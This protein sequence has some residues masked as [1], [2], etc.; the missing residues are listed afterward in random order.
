MPTINKNNYI[1]IAKAIGI[2]L[3]VVGHSGCPS[4]I[5]R[6]LYTFHMPLFFFCSGYL[7]KE[8]TDTETYKKYAKRKIK[9]LY[10][11]Y[12]KWSVLFLLLHN[13][14][15]RVNIYNSITH[16]SYYDYED[17]IRQLL[18]TIVMSDYELL[19]RPFWFIKALLLASIGVASISVLQKYYFKNINKI[20]LLFLFHILTGISKFLPS[21]PIIGDISIPLFGIVYF[22]TGLLLNENKHYLNASLSILIGTFIIV[23]IGCHLYGSVIDM[24]YTTVTNYIPYY[25]LSICGVIMTFIVSKLLERT[26]I[27]TWFYYIGNHTMPILALNLLALKIGNLI[28]IWYYDLPIE[29]LSSYTII[30]DYNKFF[31]VLYT[32]I[33]IC[34]PLIIHSIHKRYYTKFNN[35]LGIIK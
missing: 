30:G 12:L 35:Y 19:L 21:I 22:Y 29:I 20:Q 32:I 33:G 34:F 18:R 25:F 14:F 28:K 24:R 23:L 26:S 13:L 5:S 17:Y 15:C 4:I 6:F 16:S 27:K 8:V 11:P 31:W 2:I 3:M 1:A 7:Y 9:G 10:Y